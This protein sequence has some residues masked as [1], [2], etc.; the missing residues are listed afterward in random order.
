MFLY[1]T[2]VELPKFVLDVLSLGP[3][4]PVRDKIKEVFLFADLDRLV[5]ELREHK[6]VVEKSCEK[7]SSAN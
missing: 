7:E 1:C 4:H 5:L 6:T 2:V 3:K